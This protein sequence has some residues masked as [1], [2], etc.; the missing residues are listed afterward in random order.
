MCAGVSSDGANTQEITGILA[1]SIVK[2]IDQLVGTD[3]RSELGAY[4]TS[5]L[6]RRLSSQ[7]KSNRSDSLSF[8]RRNQS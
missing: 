8:S 6:S 3:N 4:R 7:L 1:L 2:N 5:R